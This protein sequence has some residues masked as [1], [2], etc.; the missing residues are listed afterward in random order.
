MSLFYNKVLRGN[1]AKPDGPKKWY[2]IL[3]ST[4]LK[5]TK[6]V[7]RLMADETTLN[8]KEAEISLSQAG[9]I[10]GRLL[11]D[12]HTVELEGLGTFYLT[13]NSVASDTEEEVTARSLK[14]LNIRFRPDQELQEVVNKAQLK[15][16]K[17]M[18]S[19]AK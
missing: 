19:A 7:A 12:G 2:L 13:A 15:P 9:K 5:K 1:P 4:G 14:G 11:A 10:L 8:A 18:D 17:S 3:K 6:E 16:A